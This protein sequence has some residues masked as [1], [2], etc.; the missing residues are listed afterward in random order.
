MQDACVQ[1]MKSKIWCPF[2]GGDNFV[3]ILCTPEWAWV[4]VGFGKNAVDRGLKFNDRAN[5]PRLSGRLAS[6]AKKPST[7][8]P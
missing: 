4:G 8:Q 2:Y 1:W 3:G 6:L 5:T 7:A